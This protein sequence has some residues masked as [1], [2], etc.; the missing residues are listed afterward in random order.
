MQDLVSWFD[1]QHDIMQESV[2]CTFQQNGI[3]C[4]AALHLDLCKLHLCSEDEEDQAQEPAVKTVSSRCDLSLQ[5][6][7]VNMKAKHDT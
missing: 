3:A 6:S 7:S 4:Y 2:S 5:H 1:C